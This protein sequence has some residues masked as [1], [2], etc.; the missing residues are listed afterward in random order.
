VNGGSS[1]MK[2]LFCQAFKEAL[3]FITSISTY[4]ST[5]V[6][7]HTARNPCCLREL[8]IY[9]SKVMEEVSGSQTYQ[10]TLP[11]PIFD[12]ISIPYL[13]YAWHIAHGQQ[14]TVSPIK[15][16]L[17]LISEFQFEIVRNRWAFMLPYLVLH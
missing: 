6:N 4:K 12:K 10:A 16:Q 9:L 11:L 13:D 17:N 2:L 15:P 5:Q 8:I 3:T 1:L 7:K 14:T